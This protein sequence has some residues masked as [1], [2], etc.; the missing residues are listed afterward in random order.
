MFEDEYKAFV[1]LLSR[2]LGVSPQT[3]RQIHSGQYSF[4]NK[5]SDEGKKPS[6]GQQQQKPSADG[7]SG[8]AK[9]GSA[10]GPN[11][12]KNDNDEKIKSVLTKTIMWMFTI[13]MFVAFISL[14]M[15][16]RNERPEV[17]PSALLLDRHKF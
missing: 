11:G 6:E 15:S 3:V 10:G 9:S 4:S 2:S 5:S 7:E 14:I 8:G 13:Y 1:S 17:R 12:N 16:P